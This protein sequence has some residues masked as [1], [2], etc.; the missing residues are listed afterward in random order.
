MEEWKDK[1]ISWTKPPISGMV[2]CWGASRFQGADNLPEKTLCRKWVLQKRDENV[3]TMQMEYPWK[4][5]HANPRF[6]ILNKYLVRPPCL[7]CWGMKG[8]TRRFI[9]S[10]DRMLVLCGRSRRV[11][12]HSAGYVEWPFLTVMLSPGFCG[13]AG[14]HLLRSSDEGF[15]LDHNSEQRRALVNGNMINGSLFLNFLLL[16]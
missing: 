5:Q 2:I 1:G 10:V 3:I 8:E 16:L 12:V 14:N 7:C 13:P 11:G 6:R 9:T 4:H 15:G